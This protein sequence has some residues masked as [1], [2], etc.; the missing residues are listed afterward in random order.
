MDKDIDLDKIQDLIDQLYDRNDRFFATMEGF[1]EVLYIY[2]LETIGM[3]FNF[4]SEPFQHAIVYD[5]DRKEIGKISFTPELPKS[6]DDIT[7]L[8]DK[9][10]LPE[11]FKVPILKWCNENPLDGHCGWDWF[12]LMRRS[13]PVLH[14]GKVE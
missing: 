4:I 11:N 3:S 5:L 7:Y 1:Y 10:C 2:G 9:N 12:N 14:V 8:G 13:G 6:I